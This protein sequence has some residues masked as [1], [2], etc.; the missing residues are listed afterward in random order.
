MLKNRSRSPLP[1][2]VAAVDLGSNSFHLIVARP[3]GHEL[4]VVDRLRDMVRLAAGLSAD[5][6]LEE[7][8]QE[9]ALECLSRFGQRLRDL[10]PGSVRA[11]GTNTLRRVRQGQSF[12]AKAEAALGHPIEVVS[13][14]EEARLIYLGVAHSMGTARGPRLVVDIGGGS[15]EFVIGEGG[16]ARLMESLHMGCVSLS[17]AHFPD[18]AITREAMKR[19]EVGARVE[20]E[21]VEAV[22]RA[23]GWEQAV[24]ASGTIK[25]VA[26]VLAEQGWAEYGITR[27]G[28]QKLRQALVKA[29]HVGKLNWKSLSDKRRPVF[30]GGV[31]A[32]C[33]IFQALDIDTMAVSDGALREGLLV[34]LIG[35]IRHEDIRESTVRALAAR[36]HVDAEQAGRVETTA[37][38]ALGE[39][40][41][42]WTLDRDECA[43]WLRWA[44]WLHEIGLDIAHSQYHKHGE[45]VLRHSDMA[46]FSRQ[47]QLLLA[48]L[49]RAHRRKFPVDVLTEVPDDDR[50][51]AARLAALLRLS[52]VLHR[53]RLPQPLPALSFAASGRELA[54]RFPV[55]WLAD[56]PLTQADLESEADN[57]KAAGMVLNW[58]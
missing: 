27:S 16:V 51:T 55:G 33:G 49:V 6:T 56:H 26:A 48:V 18:G 1:D 37:L 50:E 17:E 42:G 9:R 24:G 2:T 12:I 41:E 25:A 4:R 58:D 36:Y 3:Q 53:S 40:C 20:L 29:G 11:V 35:R 47:E 15:T 52:V 30:A 32:L 38:Q 28:L 7:S 21:P 23:R 8:A 14:V 54:L 57:L 34:D 44:A 45:Y 43:Q 19:A 22:F 10:P 13:G 39:V 31:A 46:G 5:G